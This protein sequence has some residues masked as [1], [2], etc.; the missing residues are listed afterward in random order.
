MCSET[1]KRNCSTF[2][3][4][5]LAPAFLGSSQKLKK[6]ITL[7]Y[8][9]ELKWR[10]LLGFCLSML[11][12]TFRFCTAQYALIVPCS[13]HFCPEYIPEPSMSLF[14]GNKQQFL[15][16]AFMN[17]TLC[18]NFHTNSQCLTSSGAHFSAISAVWWSLVQMYGQFSNYIGTQSL[19]F[20]IHLPF[21]T[22]FFFLFFFF[23]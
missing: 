2:L 5:D 12:I 6:L 20:S 10:I 9:A 4:H 7:E 13:Q 1:E 22:S 8:R 17:L 19:N 18:N 23:T 15:F 14:A 11:R 16:S 3:S 21:W